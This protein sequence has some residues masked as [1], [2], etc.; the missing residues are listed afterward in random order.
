M[1]VLQNTPAAALE[2]SG[3]TF[4]PI[5]ATGGKAKF[6][7]AVF[8]GESRDQ[9]FTE[10]VFDT[11]LYTEAQIREMADQYDRLLQHV[12][13]HPDVRLKKIAFQTHYNQTSDPV[14]KKVRRDSKIAKLKKARQLHTE[15]SS[16]LADNLRRDD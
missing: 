11:D 10:W 16:E 8:V 15:A 14:D 5:H 3:L 9:L 1:F 4:E 7:L 12:V 2:L 13:D 6:D